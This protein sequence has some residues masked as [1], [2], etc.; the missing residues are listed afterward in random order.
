M[1]DASLH[2]GRD[3]AMDLYPSA[4][5]A[6]SVRGTNTWLH[7]ICLDTEQCKY[8]RYA[9]YLVSDLNILNFWSLHSRH[10]LEN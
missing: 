2:F 9:S 4:E 6:F 3:N 8:L 5:L 10:I 1:T 7:C